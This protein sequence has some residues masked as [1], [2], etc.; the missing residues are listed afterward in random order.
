LAD[1]ANCIPQ[2]R[3]RAFRT[4]DATAAL[5]ALMPVLAAQRP[6]V[7]LDVRE[8]LRSKMFS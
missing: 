8:A 7:E 4:G 2:A 1:W 3:R 5:A 6:E